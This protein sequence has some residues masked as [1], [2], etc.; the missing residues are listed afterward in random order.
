MAKKTKVALMGCG[1]IGGFVMDKICNN[2][3]YENLEIAL[4]IVRSETSKGVDQARALGITV[5]TDVTMIEKYDIDVVVECASQATLEANGEYILSHGINLIPMSLGALVDPALLERFQKTAAEHGCK[6]IVPSGGVGGLDA[7]RAAM[8]V[9][10]DSAEMICRKPP[11]AW[12]NIPC[13][14]AAGYDLDNM[15]ETTL[16]YEGP[17]KD[18]VKEFPQNINIAAALSLASIGF[19]KT[20]VRIYADPSVVYNTHTIVCKGGNG[21]LTFTFE[22]VPV[23]THPKTT[24]QACAS[25]VAALQRLASSYCIGS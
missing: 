1:T 14:E 12:K 11:V 4:V 16:L 21:I 15:T 20:M 7:I 9:G 8:V 10:I 17:A 5:T 22:N 18:C 24:Y 3:G 6:L 2:E 19:E 13:V 23:P 25:I